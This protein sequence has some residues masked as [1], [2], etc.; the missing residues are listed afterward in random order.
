MKKFSSLDKEEQDKIRREYREKYYDDYRYSIKLFCCY[1]AFC[2]L[3]IVS[4]LFTFF[5][6]LYVGSF[7]FLT[8]FIGTFIC[9]Y[10]LELSNKKFYRFLKKKGLYIK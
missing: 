2:I 4:L 8:F 1:L 9:M 3:D 5:G 7:F 10:F 6:E